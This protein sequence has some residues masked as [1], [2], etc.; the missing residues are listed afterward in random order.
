MNTISMIISIL[1][2]FCL[3]YT[4]TLFLSSD[5]S[6]ML[7]KLSRSKSFWGIPHFK[8][9]AYIVLVP[10]IVVFCPLITFLTFNA[11]VELALAK[12]DTR[13]TEKRNQRLI[14]RIDKQIKKNDELDQFM[15]DLLRDTKVQ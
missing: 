10:V 15:D 5:F 14:K 12:W 7:D 1:Y 9:W 3:I 13:R 8:R 11:R 6:K 4:A 2:F